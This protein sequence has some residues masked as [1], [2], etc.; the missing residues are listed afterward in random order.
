MFI[1]FA[2][3]RLSTADSK[4]LVKMPPIQHLC[5]LFVL[6]QSMRVSFS[7]P[8]IMKEVRKG[9]VSAI[10]KYKWAGIITSI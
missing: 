2:E 3:Q 9:I 8:L 5:F 10:K 4:S 1:L 6:I 7:A